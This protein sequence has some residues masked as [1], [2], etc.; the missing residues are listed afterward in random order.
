MFVKVNI[1][2]K[3]GINWAE[4]DHLNRLIGSSKVDRKYT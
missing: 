1:V 2:M 3:K 4:G